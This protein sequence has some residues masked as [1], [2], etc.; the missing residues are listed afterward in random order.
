M[1]SN[2]VEKL[3]SL[4]HSYNDWLVDYWCDY[5]DNIFEKV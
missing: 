3:M 4:Y 5:F 1:L 2:E